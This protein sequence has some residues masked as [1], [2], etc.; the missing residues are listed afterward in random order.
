MYIYVQ[1]DVADYTEKVLLW[2]RQSGQAFPTWSLAA[3]MVFSLSASSAACERV[4]S[5][6]KQMFGEQQVLYYTEYKYKYVHVYRYLL[7][8][9]IVIGWGSL[10]LHTGRPHDQ[11]QRSHGRL[12]HRDE[13]GALSPTGCSVSGRQAIFMMGGRNY[14]DNIACNK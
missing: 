13:S 12:R 9:C 2:W 6:L 11:V 10:R 14:C 5:L 3:R 8:Y 1:A 4:F 7:F